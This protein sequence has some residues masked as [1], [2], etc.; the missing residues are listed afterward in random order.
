MQ[1]PCQLADVGQG[2]ES[3][4]RFGQKKSRYVT[5][6]GCVRAGALS[7]QESVDRD[8]ALRR[9]HQ[10]RHHRPC[11]SDL[12]H[13]VV[14]LGQSLEIIVGVHMEQPAGDVAVQIVQ[15]ARN[16]APFF[17]IE[18]TLQPYHDAASACQRQI[19]RAHV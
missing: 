13:Q 4:S 15:V 14:H 19:G 16:V 5:V 6:A 17:E 11:A 1:E 12:A 9:W 10:L 18:R 2:S 8:L 7:A 3:A